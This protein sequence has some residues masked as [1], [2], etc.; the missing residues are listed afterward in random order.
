MAKSDKAGEQRR[1]DELDKMFPRHELF[2]ILG[3]NLT[4]ELL[5]MSFLQCL[6]FS[7]IAKPLFERAAA[8]GMATAD[9]SVIG[10]EQFG[11]MLMAVTDHSD[12]FISGLALASGQP[13]EFIERLPPRIALDLLM[14]ILRINADF[15]LAGVAAHA[16][17]SKAT[18]SE[19][20]TSWPGAG[21][22]H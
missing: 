6:Q 5:P 8:L 12:E 16:S 19:V 15:F 18:T 4:L 14:T 11:P 20:E 2:P 1:A 3:T 13:K 10:P 7:R 17:G 21:V 22:M 9:F